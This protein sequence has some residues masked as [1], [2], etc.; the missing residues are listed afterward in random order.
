MLLVYDRLLHST[1]A[2]PHGRKFE[3][4]IACLSTDD[5]TVR[6]GQFCDDQA[7][8]LPPRTPTP[9][10]TPSSSPCSSSSCSTLACLPPQAYSKTLALLTRHEPSTLVFPDWLASEP[11]GSV[12]ERICKHEHA[13]CRLDHLPR[14]YW[15]DVKG[16]Q[17]APSTHRAPAP[18][19][20]RGVSLRGHAPT[21][22]AISMAIS[23]ELAV[24]RATS[25]PAPS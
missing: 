17:C 15:H 10:P 24:M 4:G 21:P 13:A 6:L 9:A 20:R 18:S 1:R 22:M 16:M 2:A 3:L 23:P 12:L 11:H 14:K 8:C 25:R 19:P 5:Y 7:R